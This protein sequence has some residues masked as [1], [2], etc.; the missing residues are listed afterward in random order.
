MSL[1]ILAQLKS[2]LKKTQPQ[3]TPQSVLGKAVNYLASNWSRLERYVETGFLP[4][5]NN[6]T[7]RAIKTFVIGR[8]AWLFSDMP[9]GATASAQIYSLVETAKVN[10]Q[11][12]YGGCATYWSDCHMRSRWPNTKRC[13]R[14]TA[15]R[16][17]HGKPVPH[18]AVGEFMDHVLN[19]PLAGCSE[20]FR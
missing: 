4:I 20:L 10:G 16:K 13:C 14:G 11:E 3:V 17:C 7:E 2:W 19:T 5:D 9:K 6:P 1:P 18:L 8:K 15:H 12:P